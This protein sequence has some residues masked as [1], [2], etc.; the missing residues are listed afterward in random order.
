MPASLKSAPATSHLK[1]YVDALRNFR[2]L[3]RGSLHLST[4]STNIVGASL[5]LLFF[6]SS[7]ST[8]IRIKELHELGLIHRW[9]LSQ[10]MWQVLVATT[11]PCL[12]RRDQ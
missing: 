3:S 10:P 7:R 4:L 11:P 6:P 5:E 9:K 2:A 12:D 8:Q 1:D